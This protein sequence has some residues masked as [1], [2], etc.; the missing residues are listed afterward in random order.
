MDMSISFLDRPAA[1]FN[2][3]S[4][5]TVPALAST[6]RLVPGKLIEIDLSLND[7]GIEMSEG[8]PQPPAQL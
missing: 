4:S 5:G 7:E 1:G 6:M 2:S 8:P 3:S